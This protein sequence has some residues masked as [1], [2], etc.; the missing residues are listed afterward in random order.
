MRVKFTFPGI[1][2]EWITTVRETDPKSLEWA[3][4]GPCPYYTAGVRLK[5]ECDDGLIYVDG[6]VIGQYVFMEPSAKNLLKWKPE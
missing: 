1:N 6:H 3:L 4:H 2:K 5:M